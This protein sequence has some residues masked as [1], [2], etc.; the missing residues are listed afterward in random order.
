MQLFDLCQCIMNLGSVV[1]CQIPKFLGQLSDHV[2]MSS[3]GPNMTRLTIS[4]RLAKNGGITATLSWIMKYKNLRLLCGGGDKQ[5]ATDSNGE[6][7]TPPRYKMRG[8][9]TKINSSPLLNRQKCGEST[10]KKVY[11]CTHPYK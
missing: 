2:R 9:V 8:M 7:S 11:H 10:K 6:I 1:S 5:A 3:L 4:F